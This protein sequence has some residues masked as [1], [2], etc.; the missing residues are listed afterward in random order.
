MNSEGADLKTDA[1]NTVAVGVDCCFASAVA[2]P[3]KLVI[4]ISNYIQVA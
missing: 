2:V 1:V 3:G 4:G